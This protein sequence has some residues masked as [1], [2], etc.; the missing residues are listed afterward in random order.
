MTEPTEQE[1]QDALAWAETKLDDPIQGSWL[2][3]K[4][5]A[6]VVRA[7]GKRIEEKDAEIARLRTDFENLDRKYLRLLNERG[8]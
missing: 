6:R 1:K 3:A 5:L 7:Q 2:R 8:Y 4:V